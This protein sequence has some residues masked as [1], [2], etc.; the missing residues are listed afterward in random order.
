MKQKFLE[1]KHRQ[2]LKDHK[3]LA[4]DVIRNIKTNAILQNLIIDL[5]E[6]MNLQDIGKLKPEEIIESAKGRI[7]K[8][9]LVN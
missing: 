8:I 4:E 5:A 3:K 2:L 7:A 9:H 1:L 6:H